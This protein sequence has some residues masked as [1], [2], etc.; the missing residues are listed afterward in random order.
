LEGDLVAEAFEL[1]DEPVAVTV[2][3]LGVSAVEEFLAEIV[4]GDALVEDVVGGGE[5]LVSGRDGRFGVAAAALDALVAGAEVGAFGSDDRFRTF[6]QGAAQPFGAFAGRPS[7]PS[8]CETAFA[9]GLLSLRAR[10]DVLSCCSS[11]QRSKPC[12]SWNPPVEAVWET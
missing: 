1:F 5:D 2:G 9:V 10:T 11:H 4:V 12:R 7:L 3:V 8:S 6:G